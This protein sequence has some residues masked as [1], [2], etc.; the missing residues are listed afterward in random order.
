MHRPTVSDDGIIGWTKKEKKFFSKKKIVIG[1]LINFTRDF[2]TDTA[3][4][5]DI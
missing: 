1:E 4:T 5:K 2:E 3:L